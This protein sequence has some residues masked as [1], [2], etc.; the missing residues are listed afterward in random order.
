MR[1]VLLV[2]RATLPLVN[3]DQNLVKTTAIVS[4]TLLAMA[5]EERVVVVPVHPIL[6]VQ[7]TLESVSRVF[8]KGT[9]V[10]VNPCAC[11]TTHR[12]WAR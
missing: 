6:I 1:I 7:R 9:L 5:S 2:T 4:I 8:A 11:R 3:A 12:G 10:N